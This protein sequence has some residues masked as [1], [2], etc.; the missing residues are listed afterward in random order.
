MTNT[1]RARY[2]P[3]TDVFLFLLPRGSS[4]AWKEHPSYRFQVTFSAATLLRVSIKVKIQSH[5]GGARARSPRFSVGPS[6]YPKPGVLAL[7]PTAIATRSSYS[8][9]L[10]HE[11]RSNSG[12]DDHRSSIIDHPW[13]DNTWLGA[14]STS[15]RWLCHT[16]S[17]LFF[18]PTSLTMG[19]KRQ[20]PSTQDTGANGATTEGPHSELGGIGGH[21]GNLRQVVSTTETLADLLARQ[22]QELTAT[23]PV[24]CGFEIV[25]AQIRPIILID[26]SRAQG[27]R[28]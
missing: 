24:L 13:F 10:G 17:G 11:G 3:N 25:C 6:L 23:I 7:N 18:P 14:L 28:T 2:L 20:N 21:I 15:V 1:T 27:G 5:R 4:K 19:K 8:K 9:H 22:L 26:L 12:R 16:L